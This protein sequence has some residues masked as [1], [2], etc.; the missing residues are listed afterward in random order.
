LLRGPEG[1]HAV[2]LRN[3]RGELLASWDLSEWSSTGATPEATVGNEA[4]FAISWTG[5]AERVLATIA[6]T[7]LVSV[8]LEGDAERISLPSR[9]GNLVEASW[10]PTGDRIAML[11]I[12]ADGAGVVSLVSPY[13]DGESFRQVIPPAA[14]AANL[15]SVTQFAWLP[16]GSGLVYI[17]AQDTRATNPGGNLYR[18]DLQNRQRQVVATPGR[19]GPTAQIVEFA[20]APDGSAVSYVIAIPSDEVWTYHSLWI[21]SLS[22][23][24]HLQVDTPGQSNVTGMWWTGPGFVWR[25]TVDDRPLLYYA[26]QRTDRVEIWDSALSDEATPVAA[27]PV[28]MSPA[29][30][31]VAQPIP[32]EG[33]PDPE[34]ATPV[35]SPAAS[36]ESTPIR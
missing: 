10:S 12:G 11:G 36:P 17:L 28:A 35:A 15:G 27:S 18:L 20:L 25:T 30:P 24:L 9:V 16:D 14:D 19:G 21:R 3:T 23:A 8:N 7:T 13:V 2:E 29:S 4:G 5:D 34:S 33:T 26:D 22:S 1:Q 32:A 31:E 6:G